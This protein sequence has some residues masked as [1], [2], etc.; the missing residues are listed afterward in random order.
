MQPR[1]GRHAG[2]GFVKILIASHSDGQGGAARAAYRLHRALVESGDVSRML[3][4]R[5]TTDDTLVVEAGARHA[6]SRSMSRELREQAER[7]LTKL[8][9]PVDSNPRTFG[10]VPGPSGS[11]LRRTSADLVNLHWIGRGYLSVLQLARVKKPVIWTLHDM[12]AFCGAEHYASC[13]RN[14][15][16]RDGYRREN[17]SADEKGIDLDRYAWLHKRQSLR[18]PAQLVTPSRW[19]ADQVR[20]SELMQDWP[21]VVIPNP[22]PTDVFRPYSKAFARGVLGLPT[23]DPLVAFGAIGGTRD[24]R[25]GWDLLEAALPLVH[26]DVPD[27]QAVIFGE[28]EPPKPPRLGLPLHFAGRLHDDMS[29]SLLY[30]AVDV[31]VVPSRQENLPQTAT[32][33]Q[34]CGTPVVVFGTTGTRET[35]V[36]GT[37]GRVVDHLDPRDLAAALTSVLTDADWSRRAGDLA[38]ARAAAEWAPDV[39]ASRYTELAAEILE[40]RQA[41]SRGVAHRSLT[42]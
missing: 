28:P 39:V 6:S 21:C 15:R 18:Q 33:A 30:S 17:R 16:W 2:C 27:A 38:R 14:A 10:L 32:E 4:D 3:V 34:A 9:R 5:K 12:W 36:D 41:S 37:T 25:K 42:G 1:S 24:P 26:R 35:V 19:L 23:D 8:Q 40:R 20:A 31:M 22:V 13:D 11:V 29:L 7:M